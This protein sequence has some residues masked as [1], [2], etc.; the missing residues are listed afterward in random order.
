MAAFLHLGMLARTFGLCFGA[1]W[2]SEIT[3]SSTETWKVWHW[4]DCGKDVCTQC[5]SCNEKAA[6]PRQPELKG[7]HWV[8]PIVNCPEHVHA[9]QWV[10]RHVSIR[11]GTTDKCSRVG[12]FE[13]P[14][15]EYRGLTVL[16]FLCNPVLF[17]LGI[18][19]HNSV[20]AVIALRGWQPLVDW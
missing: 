17:I 18:Y 16:G 15:S 9:Y 8:S 5:E 3:T 20:K 10:Q 7:A 12:E 11:L 6:L 14:E 1:L 19:R 4:I 2:D 13:N